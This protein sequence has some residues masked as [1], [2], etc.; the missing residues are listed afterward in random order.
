ME[1]TSGLSP[2]GQAINTVEMTQNNSVV[3]RSGYH[4]PAPSGGNGV[5]NKL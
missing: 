1:E 2:V 3:S 5:V 4:A